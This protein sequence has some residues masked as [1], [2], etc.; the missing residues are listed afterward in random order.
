[1]LISWIEF[2]RH[3]RPDPITAIRCE[4]VIVVDWETWLRNANPEELAEATEMLVKFETTCDISEEMVIRGLLSI[5]NEFKRRQRVEAVPRDY[6]PDNPTLSG[7][8]TKESSC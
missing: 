5:A 6:P 2:L 4:S 8:T 7:G 1:M 3:S